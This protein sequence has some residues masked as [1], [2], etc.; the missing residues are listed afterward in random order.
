MHGTHTSTQTH[1][2][3]HTHT[4]THACK[5]THTHTLAA[6]LTN[7]NAAAHPST[8]LG[9][10]TIRRQVQQVR[11]VRARHA[12][13]THDQMAAGHTKPFAAVLDDQSCVATATASL[14]RGRAQ[15]Q[16]TRDA[17]HSMGASTARLI[18]TKWPACCRLR[19][20]RPGLRRRVRADAGSAGLD[21]GQHG[22]AHPCA[23]AMNWKRGSS[24][25]SRLTVPLRGLPPTLPQGPAQPRQN[26]AYNVRQTTL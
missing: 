2:H 12:C 18:G 19:F 14:V 7:C 3:T 11:A 8:P 4:H 20:A 6:A 13:A 23:T 25:S 10:E 15:Q 1:A 9:A 22:R 21:A 24:P 17:Q 16:S 5:H 26:Q